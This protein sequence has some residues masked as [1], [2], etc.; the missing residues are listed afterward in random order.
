M[1]KYILVSKYRLFITIYQNSVNSN[2]LLQILKINTNNYY[3]KQ[4]CIFQIEIFYLITTHLLNTT[5]IHKFLPCYLL[6]NNIFKTKQK[7]E[8][9]CFEKLVL[10]LELGCDVF[11]LNFLK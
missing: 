5:Y 8:K 7:F 4:K 3:N 9:R 2:K 10:F 1:T 11:G 6:F